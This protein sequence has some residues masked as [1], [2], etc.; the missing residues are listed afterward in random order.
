VRTP[1]NATTNA[2]ASV[3]AEPD[4]PAVAPDPPQIVVAKTSVTVTTDPVDATI[5]LEDDKKDAPQ[6]QPRSIAVGADDKVVIRVERA[7]Y[8]TMKYTLDGKKVDAHNPRV[9][10]RLDRDMSKTAPPPVKSPPTAP[11]PAVAPSASAA[12][13]PAPTL[14]ARPTWCSVEDWDPFLRKCAKR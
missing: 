6:Q 14:T 13:P 5:A 4:G 12:P 11:K 2:T 3:T 7:G 10:L 9:V 8:K 1:A